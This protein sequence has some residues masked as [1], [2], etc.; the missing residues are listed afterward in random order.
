MT[1]TLA[2]KRI[3]ITGGAGFIGSTLIGMLADAND[4]VVYD[5]LRRNALAGRSYEHH[6]RL[7]LVHGDVLDSTELKKAMDGAN[8]VVH[9]AAVAGIDTVIKRPTETMRIN[10]LGAANVLEAAR[11]QPDHVP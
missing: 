9:C 10:M 7:R 3:F 4:I 11:A 1:P 5:N 8:L 6:P 2:N